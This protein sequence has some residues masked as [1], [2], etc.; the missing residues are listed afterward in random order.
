MLGMVNMVWDYLPL[1]PTHKTVATIYQQKLVAYIPE[2]GTSTAFTHSIRSISTLFQHVSSG[3]ATEAGFTRN[4]TLGARIRKVG[5]VKTVSPCR[6]GQYLAGQGQVEA[7][8]GEESHFAN[9]PKKEMLSSKLELSEALNF[10]EIF[11]QIC[12]GLI[13]LFIL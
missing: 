5:P 13:S 7:N 3:S 11:C 12:Y 2:Y 6:W 10:T 9:W 4:S 8:S 1:T